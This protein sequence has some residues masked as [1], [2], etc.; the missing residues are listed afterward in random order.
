MPI[1][2]RTIDRSNLR[3]IL[4]LKV[5]D[6]ETDFVA[7]N[8]YSISE[9]YVEEDLHPRAI[10]AHSNLVGFV[11]Y[12]KWHGADSYWITRLMIAPEHRG[13]GYAKLAIQEAIGNL[14]S[15]PDCKKI[16]I[17]FTPN[18]QPA[19]ALYQSL[20]FIETGKIE[21]EIRFELVR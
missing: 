21:D 11:M 17:S 18:N 15:K 13:R 9:A 12:G 14:F 10:Y 20:G 8:A 7:P 16:S 6:D 1:E 19:R 4:K 5:S 3:S 2:L